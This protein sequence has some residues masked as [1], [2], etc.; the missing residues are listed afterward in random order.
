MQIIDKNVETTSTVIGRFS[1]GSDRQ[2]VVIPK[3]KVK[4]ESD[5]RFYILTFDHDPTEQEV[6]DAFSVGQFTEVTTVEDLAIKLADT[7]ERL[8]LAEAALNELILGG[9]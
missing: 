6:Q 8:S 9:V 1:D 4:I 3:Y 2:E 5:D 7:R